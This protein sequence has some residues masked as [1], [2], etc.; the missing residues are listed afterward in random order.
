MIAVTLEALLT[1]TEADVAAP[2]T[3]TATR[4]L[5]CAGVVGLERQ[6]PEETSSRQ[7]AETAG[8]R[9]A[10]GRAPFEPREYVV[11]DLVL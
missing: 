9:A 1:L 4:S 2:F 6:A 10:D 11:S 8:A 5:H 3:S 7:R